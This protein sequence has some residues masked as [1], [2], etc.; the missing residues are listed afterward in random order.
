MKPRI[1]TP[2]H[3]VG[4][5]ITGETLEVRP[6][7]IVRV[8]DLEKWAVNLHVFTD[9]PN[10]AREDGEPVPVWHPNVRF[11]QGNEPNTWHWPDGS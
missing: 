2:V 5:R 10:D 3:Y 7:V 11:S 8:T 6:A 1:G 9:G 4:Q